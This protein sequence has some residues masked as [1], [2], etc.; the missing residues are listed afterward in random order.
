MPATN[1]R[2]IGQNAGGIR[3]EADVM[4]RCEV[5]AA[6][7]CWRWLGAMS[8]PAR[9]STPIPVCYHATVGKVASVR[10]VLRAI[11]GQ[12]KT[13]RVWSTC[14][15]IA[16]ICPAHSQAGTAAEF[17]AWIK[18]TAAWK[19]NPAK[20]AACRRAA[21]RYP[22]T[23]DQVRAIRLMTTTE[24]QAAFGISYEVAWGIR[25]RRSRNHVPDV[26]PSFGA[27]RHAVDALPPGYVSRLDA[28]ECRAWASAAAGAGA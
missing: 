10:Q 28:R 8:S 23:D 24:A 25:T 2:G 14:G 6:C 26:K 18:D 4:A 17:Y 3:T 9:A 27:A 19:R 13:A 15:D 5:D 12:P 20:V 7:G 16:C 1:I 22:L 11:A 21:V